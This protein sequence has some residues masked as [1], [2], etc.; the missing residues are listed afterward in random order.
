MR[1]ALVIDLDGTLL[2]TNTFRDYLRFSCREALA[3]MRWGVFLGILFYSLLRLL[4]LVSHARLKYHVLCLT[5]TLSTEPMLQRF[6]DRELQSL[7]PQV[8]GLLSEYS[9][10]GYL[11]VLATAAPAHYASLLAHKLG[12]E[13]C[14]ATPLPTTSFD[15]WQECR[16]EEKLRSVSTLLA[17]HEATLAVVV[18]DH[19]DDRPLLRANVDGKNIL[20]T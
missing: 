16:G 2:R 20:C 3:A 6:V 7:N 1:K 10:Q 18:T 12:F 8:S 15:Q 13:A 17:T 11:T 14:C 5:R 19:E 9:Q 4:R